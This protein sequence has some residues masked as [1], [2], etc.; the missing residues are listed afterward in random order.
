MGLAA[1]LGLAALAVGT[2]AGGIWLAVNSQNTGATPATQP[3]QSAPATP[4]VPATQSAPG[5]PTVVALSGSIAFAS[6][7]EGDLEIYVMDADGSNVTRLTSLGDFAKQDVAP[8]WS[9]DGT[10]IAFISDQNNNWEVYVM[11]ADGSNVT[12][13]TNHPSDDDEAA[14]SATP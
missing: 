2:V 8:A 9:P 5:S 1:K 14:W 11:G 3:T 13:L 10:R 12:R 6:G 4:T 7:R